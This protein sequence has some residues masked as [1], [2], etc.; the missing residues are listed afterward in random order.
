[1]LLTPDASA[2]APLILAPG[3]ALARGRAHEASG[4]SRHLFALLVGARL[5]GP[6]LWLHPAWAV[7]RLNGDGVRR[8]LD[9]GRLIL[10]RARTAAELLWAAEEALRTGLVPLVVVEL[11]APPGLTPVRR[12]HLA[13]EEGATRAEAPVALLLTPERGGAPGVETRWQMAPIS[14]WA[15]D[16]RPRWR[17]IR[18]RARMAPVQG[19]DLG[20]RG[21]QM[22]LEP[23]EVGAG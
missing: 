11:A 17:L 23:V 13:A 16:E 22:L 20:L 9:P 1:M 6:I 2:A 21:G 3:L 5:A 8:H 19:W 4:A 10:G 18:T 14:G 15:L 7:E 12:L